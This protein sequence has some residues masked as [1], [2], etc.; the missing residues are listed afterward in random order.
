MTRRRPWLLLTSGVTI[1][2]AGCTAVAGQAEM[3]A[4]RGGDPLSLQQQAAEVAS[5]R[6]EVLFPPR[7]ATLTS[8]DSRQLDLL[9][10]LIRDVDPVTLLTTA[11]QAGPGDERANALAGRRA[12]AVKRGLVARGIPERQLSVEVVR[13]PESGGAPVGQADDGRVTIT[14]GAS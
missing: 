4:L 6:V 9:V 1:F 2:L 5:N 11:Y 3:G 7:R 8:E 10:R 13:P 12:L 14:W